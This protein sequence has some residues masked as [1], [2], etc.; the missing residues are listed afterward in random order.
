MQPAHSGFL[1]H[2]FLPQRRHFFGR[3]EVPALDLGQSFQNRRLFF[4]RHRVMAGT[5]RLNL[6]RGLGQS[7]LV[8]GGPVLDRGQQ[9]L[10]SAD[11]GHSIT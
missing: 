3:G 8:L 10:E 7:L 9:V 6:A 4:R 2:E 1:S 11:H 5:R